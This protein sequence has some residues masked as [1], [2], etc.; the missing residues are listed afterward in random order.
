MNEELFGC[1]FCN[2]DRSEQEILS[3]ISEKNGYELKSDFK[4]ISEPVTLFH[5]KCGNITSITPQNFLFKKVRC[6][7]ETRITREKAKQQIEK[8]GLF[9]L[10]EYT[11]TSSSCIMNSN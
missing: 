3:D 6:L 10:I 7:C 11:N 2:T 8:A 9:E 5:R 1:P 4:S